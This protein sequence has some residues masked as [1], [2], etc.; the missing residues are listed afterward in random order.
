MKQPSTQLLKAVSS[1]PSPALDSDPRPPEYSDDALALKFADAFAQD[2][3]YVAFW[4]SWLTW[5]GGR[6]ASDNTLKVFDDAR[7]IC[8]SVAA[9]CNDTKLRKAIAS[10]ATVAAV[11]RLSRSDRRMAASAEQFDKDPWLLN[12]PGGVIDLRSGE[13]RPARRADLMTKLTEAGPGEDGCPTWLDFLRQITDGDFELERFLARAVGY[14]L[15]GSTREHAFFFL[16][17]TGGNGKSVFVE[18]ISALLSDYATAAPIEMFT[19]TKFQSHTTDVAGLQGARMVS[20]SETGAG[21]SLDEARIKLLT[22]GDSTAARRMRADNVTFKPQFKLWMTGNHKPR[23]QTT[24]EAI[25]RRIHLIP[26]TVQIPPWRRDQKLAEKLK[27]EWPGIL[28]WAISGCREWQEKGLAPPSSVREATDDYLN[29]EDTLLAWLNTDVLSDP[30]AKT[31][32]TELFSAWMGWALAANETTGTQKDFVDA[33]RRKQLTLEHTREG[34]RWLGI[35][36]KG[37]SQ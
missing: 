10:A 24:D 35:S 7:S 21:R 19:Q 33:L 27:A 16:F 31:P 14:S 26:F 15:T 37:K 28:S 4:R 6:W 20:A 25:R 22:G 12:T 13:C 18:T 9:A 2:R 8:R 1:P 29:A 34:N 17:G 11:E 30:A 36:L 3:R 23:I 32:T 5:D